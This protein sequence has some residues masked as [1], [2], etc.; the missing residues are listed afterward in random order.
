[1][2]MQPGTRYRVTKASKDKTFR[3]GDQVALHE[4]GSILNYTVSGW[5]E[6]ADVSAATAGWEIAVDRE[7]HSVKLKKLYA[8]IELIRGILNDYA[9]N[10]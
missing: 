1:M 5:Q 4:D 3:V 10:P 6:A 2:N 8:E 7:W 9:P